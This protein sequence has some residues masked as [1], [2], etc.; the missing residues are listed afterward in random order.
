MIKK[1]LL[2][3]LLLMLF[4][5][6][7][8]ETVTPTPTQTNNE[9]FVNFKLDGVQKSYKHTTC[10]LNSGVS[11]TVSSYSDIFNM[12]SNGYF[13]IVGI[14]I[15][16]DKDS[17]LGSDLLNLA[18]KTLPLNSDTSDYNLSFNYDD[19]VI[20]FGTGTNVFPTNFIKFNTVTYFKTVEEFGQKRKHYIATG[21]FNA[22]VVHNTPMNVTDGSFKLIFTE[23][24]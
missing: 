9:F 21:N 13:Y 6:C 23:S 14:G 22:K 10:A 3:S 8:K 24:F 18:G 4:I 1:Y 19:G 20:D 7:K 5:S 16:M 17:L 15:T 11:S 2:F 12:D